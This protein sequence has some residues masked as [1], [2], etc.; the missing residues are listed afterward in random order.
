MVVSTE[1]PQSVMDLAAASGLDKSTS[2]RLLAF[3]EERG[4]LVRDA[5][6]RCYSIGPEL[7][8]I[9]AVALRR[10]DVR[11]VCAPHMQRLRDVTGE[12]VSLHLRRNADRICVDTAES[13]HPVRHVVPVGV[14]VPL[15]S[16]P[17]G[18]V[19]LANLP[20]DEFG[21]VIELG[22]RAGTDIPPVLG[23]VQKARDNGYLTTIGAR[24]AS[25]A[26]LSV[27]IFDASGVIASLTIAGPAERWT[28]DEMGPHV[29]AVL[30]AAEKT[31]HAL[32][33][34]ARHWNSRPG[35]LPPVRTRSTVTSLARARVRSGSREE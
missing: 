4:F 30:D 23:L 21:Q 5:A 22:K 31:S 25:E 8:R 1:D 20:A 19:I 3:L 12:T 6:T 24:V 10:C 14:P 29:P 9:G 13:P 32:G 7:L 17:S 11:R 2:S 26:A 18:L 16:G 27:P 15:Y 28:V 35:G 34:G 33:G